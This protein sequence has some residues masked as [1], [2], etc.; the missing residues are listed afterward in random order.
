MEE[1]YYL[2]INNCK[3]K[4]NVI[5]KNTPDD[6]LIDINSEKELLLKELFDSKWL[7]DVFNEF[8]AFIHF[9]YK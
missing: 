6:W 9:Q 5:L 4:L 3:E 1:N 2:C 8:K 7:K